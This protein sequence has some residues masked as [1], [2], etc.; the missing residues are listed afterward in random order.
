MRN[1]LKIFVVLG[2]AFALAA[3]APSLH[4]FFT[5][6]DIVFNDELLGEWVNDS[7]E[8]CKFTKSGANHYEFLVED[9]DPA[10]FKA[11]LFKLGDVTYLDL[12]PEPLSKEEPLGKAIDTY[13]GNIVVGHS[14]AR[15][16][17]GKNSISI[18]M[19]DGDWLKELSD[20]KRINLAH[21]RLDGGAIVLT[22][23]T[24]D[25]QYFVLKHA[26]DKELFD[27]DE[28]FHRVK[29]I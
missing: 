8:K 6:E 7:G 11:R 9:E 4:P 29:S 18:A 10:R 23:P 28:V 21:E 25:L 22:A 24:R 14:L 3:C 27:D 15:V 26:G 16:T 13:P 5:E 17:I 20:Q 1:I 12:Y 19:M 2:A